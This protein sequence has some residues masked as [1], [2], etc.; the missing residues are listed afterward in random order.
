M[1]NI[2]HKFF[3]DRY[4]PDQSD[5]FIRA[6]IVFNFRQTENKLFEKT[7][8]KVFTQGLQKLADEQILAPSQNK[9]FEKAKFDKYAQEIPK[10]LADF[11][12][13]NQ[14]LDGNKFD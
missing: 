13:R 1:S 7:V 6:R 11:Y 12:L 4:A 10:V 14:D 2:C 3:K 5:N 9:R 8:K